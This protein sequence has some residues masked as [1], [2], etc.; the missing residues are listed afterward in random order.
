MK[1]NEKSENLE[2]KFKLTKEQTSAFKKMFE[3]IKM[4]TSD[5]LVCFSKDSM[6]ISFMD[7]KNKSGHRTKIKINEVEYK[8]FAKEEIK[9]YL[10]AENV[11]SS[12]KSKKNSVEII[13]YSGQDHFIFKKYSEYSSI[14]SETIINTIN[15]EIK[16]IDFGDFDKEKSNVTIVAKRFSETCGNATKNIKATFECYE[17]GIKVTVENTMGS[18]RDGTE[19]GKIDGECYGKVEIDKSGVK[20]LSKMN[21]LCPQAYNV[22]FFIDKEEE[23]LYIKIDVWNFGEYVICFN[24]TKN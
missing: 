24:I 15:L 14:A 3:I 1:S 18:Y 21:S 17:K 2:L 6:T 5:V 4:Y 9:V 19:L 23:L 12:L 10:N 13:K 20:P 22:Y 16:D 7:E 11:V 8:F